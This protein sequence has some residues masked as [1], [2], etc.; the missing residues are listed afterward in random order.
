MTHMISPGIAIVVEAGRAMEQMKALEM[1]HTTRVLKMQ[2]KMVNG[3]TGMSM[4]PMTITTI[5]ATSSNST[6]GHNQKSQTPV[7]Q[8]STDIS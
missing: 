4:S 7:K 2:Q 8:T 5:R 3:G 6:P 1:G